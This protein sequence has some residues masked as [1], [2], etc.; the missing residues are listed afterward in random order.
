[1]ATL[2]LFDI[3]L[4][5]SYNRALPI[6]QCSGSSASEQRGP[7]GSALRLGHQYSVRQAVVRSG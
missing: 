7:I 1:M 2:K 6:V 5:H 3:F 4:I